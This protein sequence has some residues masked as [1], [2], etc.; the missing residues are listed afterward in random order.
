MLRWQRLYL[1]AEQ[2]GRPTTMNSKSPICVSGRGTSPHV[3][4][5]LCQ[6]GQ[7]TLYL[8]EIFMAFLDFAVCGSSLSITRGRR[9]LK[10]RPI[11]KVARQRRRQT[12]CL[13]EYLATSPLITLDDRSNFLRSSIRFH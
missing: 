6:L 8:S 1:L 10:T 5:Q 4:E 13:G 9:K 3:N 7:C 12:H 11:Q 2:R